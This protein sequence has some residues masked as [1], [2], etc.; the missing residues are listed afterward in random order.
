MC[1]ITTAH[2]SQHYASAGLRGFGMIK[3]VLVKMC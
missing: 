1:L 2:Q 3:I